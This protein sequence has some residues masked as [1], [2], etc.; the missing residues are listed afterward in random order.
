M[1]IIIPKRK[2]KETSMVKNMHWPKENKRKQVWLKNAL[3]GS[4]L[5]AM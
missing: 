2:Q 3:T 5:E 1:T 4:S